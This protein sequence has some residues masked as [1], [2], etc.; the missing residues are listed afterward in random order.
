MAKSGYSG[1]IRGPYSPKNPKKYVGDKVPY[2]RSSW[3]RVFMETCD[4]NPNVIEW[5]SE[6]LR[7]PY[8]NPFKNAWTVYVPDFVIVYRDKSRSTVAELIEIKPKKETTLEAAKTEKDKINVQINALKWQAGAK[9]A[10][11]NGLRFRVLTEE[12]IFQKY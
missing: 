9:Y 5:A 11:N 12:H 6:P 1:I 2:Y 3:E 4:M 10:S 8:F 7:I